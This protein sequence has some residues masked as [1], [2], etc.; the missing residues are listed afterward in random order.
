MLILCYECKMTF[1]FNNRCL[2]KFQNKNKKKKLL[3][4]KF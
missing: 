2:N 1:Q 3:K 4:N